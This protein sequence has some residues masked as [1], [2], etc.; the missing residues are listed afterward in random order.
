MKT[1]HISLFNLIEIFRRGTKKALHT[2]SIE[3]YCADK[4]IH[5]Y[6]CDTES[7]Q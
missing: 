2:L 6:Y 3:S 1:T 7:Q 4:S 5:D